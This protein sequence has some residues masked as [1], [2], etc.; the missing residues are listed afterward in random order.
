[1]CVW[2]VHVCVLM[3][4]C[5]LCVHLWNSEVDVGV[6]YCSTPYV[7]FYISVWD[8]VW[9]SCLCMCRHACSHTCRVHAHI[10]AHGDKRMGIVA[11]LCCS[12]R[13]PIEI[14]SLSEPGARLDPSDL[15]VCLCPSGPGSQITPAMPSFLRVGIQTQFLLLFL[16]VSTLTNWVIFQACHLSFWDRVTLWTLSLS[17]R[18]ACLVSQ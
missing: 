13:Y 14:D 12:L 10:S 4:L 17:F 15:P 2:C 6:F 9:W 7:Y 18:L 5:L 8:Y 1:M 16:A 3:W 11:L